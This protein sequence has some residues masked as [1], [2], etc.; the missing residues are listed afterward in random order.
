M[1]ALKF[2]MSFEVRVIWGHMDTLIRHK[3]LGRNKGTFP[4]VVRLE[5]IHQYAFLFPLAG[6][7]QNGG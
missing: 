3:T 2:Y 7:I 5:Y 6:H 4:L 1:C